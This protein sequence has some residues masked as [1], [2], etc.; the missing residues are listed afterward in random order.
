MKSE[1]SY[2]VEL[3]KHYESYFGIKGRRLHL[4]KGPVDK[5]HPEFF[6]LEFAPN[7]RHDMFCYCTVGMSADRLDDNLIELFVYSAKADDLLTEL[8]TVCASFHRNVLPLN[9]NHTVN[10]GQA[11]LENSKCDHGLISAPYLDGPDLALFEYNG[12]EIFCNWFIP[13]TKKERDFKIENGIEQL[14]QLFEDNELN[15][16]DPNRNCLLE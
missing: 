4:D 8:L 3:V 1:N 10:I 12:S 13:I 14:E 15:Y 2:S 6:V 16:L 7:A 9:L 11:W 5:L